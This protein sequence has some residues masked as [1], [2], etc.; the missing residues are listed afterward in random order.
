MFREARKALAVG[1]VTHL[2]LVLLFFALA[3]GDLGQLP[4]V[5][6]LL[7]K[8]LFTPQFLHLRKT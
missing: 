2:H 5:G 3:L 1:S 4:Q 6:G 7:I 8:R